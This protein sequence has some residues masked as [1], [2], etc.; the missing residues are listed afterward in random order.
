MEEE[1]KQIKTQSPAIAVAFAELS[2]AGDL[3]ESLQSRL[4]VLSRSKSTSVSQNFKDG[5]LPDDC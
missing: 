2:A 4:S 3:G 5:L 1:Q